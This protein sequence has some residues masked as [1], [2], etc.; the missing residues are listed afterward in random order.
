MRRSKTPI[1]APRPL[2]LTLL[3]AGNQ[4]TQRDLSLAE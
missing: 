3:E 4:V 2:T 1:T